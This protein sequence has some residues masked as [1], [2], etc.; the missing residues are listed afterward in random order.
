MIYTIFISIILLLAFFGMIFS[1]GRWFQVKYNVFTANPYVVP[2]IGFV[3]FFFVTISTYMIPFLFNLQTIFYIIFEVVKDV[4]IV[5]FLIVNK[6]HIK[7]KGNWTQFITLVLIAVVLVNIPFLI[8]NRDAYTL[9]PTTNKWFT[10]VFDGPNVGA[11]HDISQTWFMFN[12]IIIYISNISIKA[13][14][15]W[16]QGIIITFISTSAIFSYVSSIQR[17]GRLLAGVICV[18][19]VSI[20]WYVI[21]TYK[22]DYI[23]NAG[24]AAIL[25]MLPLYGWEIL[26]KP[27]V[28][29]FALSAMSVTLVIAFKPVLLWLFCFYFVNLL[30][31]YIFKSKPKIGLLFFL[32]FIFIVFS[33]I[34]VFGHIN[35]IAFIAFAIIS[36]MLFG[37]EFKKIQAK[38]FTRLMVGL[39]NYR[40]VI[41]SIIFLIFIGSSFIIYFTKGREI[42]PFGHFKLEESITNKDNFSFTGII[43]KYVS[44]SILGLIGLGKTIFIIRHRKSINLKNYLYVFGT[45]MFLFFFTPLTAP[46]LSMAIGKD[47]LEWVSWLSI[48]P[49]IIGILSDFAGKRSAL[50]REGMLSW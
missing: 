7:L 14:V 33:I 18:I 39:H 42:A 17:K 12:S 31:I 10:H 28:S 8:D 16:M 2:L 44:Y 49:I 26:S 32:H 43:I 47:K 25:L 13:N 19:L 3:I 41:L 22:G 30:I 48:M 20:G 23:I 37:F 34:V 24:V 5:V 9:G 15:Y 35:K 27:Q 1:L 38:S 45:L 6:E 4:A 11:K 40:W 21:F 50:G 29:S 36:I 46:M